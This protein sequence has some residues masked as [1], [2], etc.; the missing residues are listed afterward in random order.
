MSPLDRN[1]NRGFL[2]DVWI[3]VVLL[4]LVLPL[5]II[6]IMSLSSGKFLSFPPQAFSLFWYGETLGSTAW[7]QAAITSVQ[8]AV[9]AVLIA[10]PCAVS[11]A[12]A[13]YRLPEKARR[14]VNFLTV[15]PLIIPLIVFAIAL[16]FVFA[17]LGL[18][19][20][21]LGI[22]LGHA[23]LIM[24]FIYVTVSTA[25]EYFDDGL[26][27]AAE[28]LG[29]SRIYAWRT[30]LLPFIAPA[31]ILGAV[32]SFMT[33]FDEAVVAIFVG[34][35][36]TLTL[37]SLMWRSLNVELTPGVAAVATMVT[38]AGVVIQG[39]VLLIV[40]PQFKKRRSKSSQL[41]G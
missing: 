17:K 28:T 19:G 27:D 6:G 29:A 37:P 41:N 8:V 40:W 31:I 24:P 23:I 14:V 5:P 38:L 39:T 16:F 20:T 9:L 34:Q 3:Y 18:V 2:L 35:G 36:S 32:L 11:L 30:V 21:K 33:S 12:V 22:A 26:I 7:V 1:S 4:F 25:L 15:G 10:L 13:S